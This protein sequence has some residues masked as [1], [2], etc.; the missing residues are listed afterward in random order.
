MNLSSSLLRR[1]LDIRSAVEERGED[2]SNFSLVMN[3]LTVQ[4]EESFSGSLYG[5]R[6]LWD[7]TLPVGE[8][9]ATGEPA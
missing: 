1:A 4:A 3:P 5:M 2:P 7:A 6:L 9:F 8:L